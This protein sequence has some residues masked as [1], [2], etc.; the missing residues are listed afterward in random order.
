MARTRQKA[1]QRK[2]KRLEQERKQAER[3]EGTAAVDDRTAEA[4]NDALLEVEEAQLEAAT[5]LAE[6]QDVEVGAGAEAARHA[7]AVEAAEA[8]EIETTGEDPAAVED[9]APTKLTRRERRERREARE[10]EQRAKAAT[11]RPKER[12][13]P[14]TK[15]AVRKEPRRRGRVINF[16]IQMWAELRRV[17][18]PNRSQLTQAT[19]VVVVFCLIAGLYLGIWDWAF[20]KLIRWFL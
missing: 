14:R 7:A 2:A 20:N 17:Q 1:K 18:W 10:A 5:E 19:T 3:S 6:A 16:F 12:E 9:G 15:E 11:A 8:A 4:T 13:R